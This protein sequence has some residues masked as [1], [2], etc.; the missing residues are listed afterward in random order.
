[1]SAEDETWVVRPL[2]DGV[3]VEILTENGRLIAT[4]FASEDAEDVVEAHNLDVE[5][6][7]PA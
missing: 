5:F 1:M 4:F 6:N 2:P 7:R 3:G